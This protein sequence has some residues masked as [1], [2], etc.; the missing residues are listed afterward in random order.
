MPHPRARKRPRVREAR[1]EVVAPRGV[2]VARGLAHE[3]AGEAVEVGVADDLRAQ[4]EVGRVRGVGAARGRGGAGVAAEERRQQGGGGRDGGGEDGALVG[5]VADEEGHLRGG[6]GAHAQLGAGGRGRVVER[7][8]EGQRRLRDDG[9][10]EGGVGGA[11]AGE[12][13]GRG[14]GRGGVAAE[15]G[16]ERFPGLEAGAGV[17]LALALEDGGAE[18]RRAGRRQGEE[19]FDGVAAG[20]FAEDGD[21]GGI[22]AEGADVPLDPREGEALV[23]EGEVAFVKGDG[24]GSREA[25]DCAGSEQVK[26]CRRGRCKLYHWSDS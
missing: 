19:L 20:G 18:L 21:A 15:R 26:F 22:A 8:R 24:W 11:D 16:G 23:Q 25:K 12:L 13:V 3:V 10:D 5:V 2:P 7:G 14:G 9:A 4:G 6:A 17:A 1:V